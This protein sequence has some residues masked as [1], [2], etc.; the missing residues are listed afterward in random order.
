MTRDFVSQTHTSLNRYYWP[1]DWHDLNGEV[2][3]I[4]IEE[5]LE[6]AS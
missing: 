2:S 3:Y 4:G 5:I 6:S 1:L